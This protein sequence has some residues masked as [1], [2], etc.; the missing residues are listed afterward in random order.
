MGGQCGAYNE[1]GSGSRSQLHGGALP[2][3]ACALQGSP[4]FV[5]LGGPSEQELQ[6]QQGAFLCRAFFVG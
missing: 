5:I 1:T 3:T 4:S 6:L 2:R